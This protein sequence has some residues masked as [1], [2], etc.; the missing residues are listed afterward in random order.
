MDDNLKSYVL[1]VSLPS[2][3]M[4]QDIKITGT[5]GVGRHGIVYDAIDTSTQQ[6][7]V[8]KEFFP[9]RLATR[10]KES[11]VIPNSSDLKQE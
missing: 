10:N 3:T 2:G 6:I 4:V 8:L 9:V 11:R 5:L 1:S 7:V